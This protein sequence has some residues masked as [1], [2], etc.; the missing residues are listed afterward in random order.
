MKSLDEKNKMPWP[1]HW[2]AKLRKVIEELQL[3]YIE[4][5]SSKHKNK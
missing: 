1:A 4:H 2:V 3:T 5:S